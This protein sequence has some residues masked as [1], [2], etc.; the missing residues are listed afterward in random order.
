V[1]RAIVTG[2]SGFLGSHVARRLVRDGWAVVGVKRSTSDLTRIHDF[3]ERLTFH[4][5]DQAPVSALFSAG[6]PPDAVLHFATDYGRSHTPPSALLQANT[7]FPLELLEHAASRGTRLFLNADTCYTLQYKH[8]Q[9]YTLSK[10]QLTQ[11]GQLLATDESRFV[12]LVLQHPYGPG[13]GPSKFVPYILKQ[14]L[15]AQGDIALTPGEQRKDFIYVDDVIAA[16]KLVLD[17]ADHL[18]GTYCDLDCGSGTAISIREFVETAHRL[19]HSRARL[20]FGALPYRENEI[21]FSQAD[22]TPLR[23][24]GWEPRI[25]LDD[26]I[27]RTLDQEFGFTAANTK[28]L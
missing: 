10:K 9:S 19:T 7:L 2:V 23:R 1:K 20:R 26:G 13:D 27:R 6:R 4:D 5:A 17:R 28:P 25:S 12:N 15:E 14:C 11:W 18:G 22:I 24:L 21:M 16:V 8:L 3:A